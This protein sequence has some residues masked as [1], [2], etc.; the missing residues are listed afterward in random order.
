MSDASTQE[1]WNVQ[2]GPGVVRPMTLDEIDAAFEAGHIAAS[3]L[4]LPPGATAWTTLGAAAGLD[5]DTAPSATPAPVSADVAGPHSL[6]PMAIGNSAAHLDSLVPPPPA[7]DDVD[8]EAAHR[9]SRITLIAGAAGVVAVLA[10]LGAVGARVANQSE[11]AMN[12]AAAGPPLRETH[13]SDLDEG[14][15]STRVLTDEQKRRLEQADKAR[16]AAANAAAAKRR[17]NQ[18]APRTPFKGD[19]PFKKSSG[20]KYDPLNGSL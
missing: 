9:R 3:T 11:A 18:P 14:A 16:A 10:A 6:A 7:I 19:D 2:V 13:L 15:T 17:E 5:S 8:F 1:I 20:N 12:K 4:V